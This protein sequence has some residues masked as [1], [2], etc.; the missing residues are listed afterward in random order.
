[1]LVVFSLLFTVI[2]LLLIGSVLLVTKQS[3]HLSQGHSG[4]IAALYAAEAGVADAVE[5]LN[6]DNGWAPSDYRVTLPNGYGSYAISFAAG[7]S[8]DP[9]LSINNLQ[10]YSTVTGPRGADTVPPASVYLVVDGY[11]YGQS[12]RAEVILR[13]TPF[14][15]LRG[16]FVTSGR[17]ALSGNVQVDG[18]ESFGSWVNVEAGIHSNL[19]GVQNNV[20]TWEGNSGERAII[21]GEV[22]TSSVGP[23]AIDMDLSGV[24]GYSSHGE[25]T[26]ISARRFPRID[27]ERIVAR[28]G[29]RG[30]PTHNS[31][32]GTNEI[33]GGDHKFA[34]GVINGDLVLDN[35]N[36]Y[37]SGDLEVNGSI[38]GNGSIFVLGDTT[39]AGSASVNMVENGHIALYSQGHVKL[40]GFDGSEFLDAAAASEGF[41]DELAVTQRALEDLQQAIDAGQGSNFSDNSQVDRLRFVLGGAA[42]PTLPRPLPTG[43]DMGDVNSVAGVLGGIDGSDQTSRFLRTKFTRLR[44]MLNHSKRWTGEY[45]FPDADPPAGPIYEETTMADVQ[46]YLNTGE[47]AEGL[48]EFVNDASGSDQRIRRA[49]R[50]LASEVQSVNFDALGSSY[51]KG[52][53]FSS[54]AVHSENDV[55]VLGGIYAQRSADSPEDPLVVGLNEFH[56]GDVVMRNGCRVTYIQDL[57]E[58]PASRF[59]RHLVVPTTWLIPLTLR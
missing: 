52:L 17:I 59:T 36:L 47:M 24:G 46:N 39:F 35:C 21:R 22:T 7:P 55:E 30:L 19:S 32:V 9:N 12:R 56:P 40:E 27:V 29:D 41:E 51:F 16:P 4:R 11:A 2:L 37:V 33:T 45:E 20:I 48:L 25:E 8:S 15:T 49:R 31:V 14:E 34:G 57:V 5:R 53:I 26:G 43:Y 58:N 13:A 6:D 3:K 28:A 23:Q 1:M 42:D 44:S 18:V 10:S 50:L 38:T 54:G